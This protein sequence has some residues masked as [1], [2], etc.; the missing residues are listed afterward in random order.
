VS[1]LAAP[2]LKDAA[3]ISLTEGEVVV[4]L[5]PG[6]L[7]DAADRRRPDIE[8]V[9]ARYFGRPTRL[10]VKRGAA[11]PPGAPGAPGA[12][13]PAPASLTHVEAAERQARS[14]AVRDAAKSHPNI[15]DAAR[16][17]EGGVDKIEEL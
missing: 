11:P 1:P 6:M 2:A 17:L 12:A 7:A 14:A 8:A 16:I 5:P 10:V 9:F 3:L 4:Q 13:T 15:R